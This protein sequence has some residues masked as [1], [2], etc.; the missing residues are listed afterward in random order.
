MQNTRPYEKLKFYQDIREIR[1]F[2][3]KITE[4][5][6]KTHL[7]LASQMQDAARSAKQNIREGYRKGSLGEF[8]HSIKISQGSLEELSGDVEDCKE[9]G[10]ITEEEFVEFSRLYQSAGYLTAQYLKSL[11]KIEREDTW[12]VPGAKLRIR[13]T[14]TSRNLT[15]PHVTSRNLDNKAQAMILVLFI[16]ALIGALAGGLAV[17]WESEIR[18]RALDRDGLIA[19]YLA[20][21]GLE[22]AK[23]YAI[24]NPGVFSHNSTDISFGGGRYN[25]TSQQCDFAGRRCLNSTGWVLDGSGNT[26]ALRKLAGAV[27]L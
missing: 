27:D 9:D 20:R 7:R 15:Q 13:N 10:L 16:L 25:F 17:M 26:I 22:H 12:K 18:T 24:A 5:F 2:I 6:K 11:Y 3:Y 23:I 8:I 19:F 14:V 1:K 21:A 4:R